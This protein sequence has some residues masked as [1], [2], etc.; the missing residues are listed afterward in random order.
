[1]TDD[2]PGARDHLLFGYGLVQQWCVTVYEQC[3]RVEDEDAL[4][5]VRVMDADLLAIAVYQLHRSLEAIGQPFTGDVS[6]CLTLRHALTHPEDR[7]PELAY[8]VDGDVVGIEGW[9][10][11]PRRATPRRRIASKLTEEARAIADH[12]EPFAIQFWEI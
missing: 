12:A 9:V 10:L 4:P 7:D 11:G 1:M 3:K 6:A 8:T 5:E 2:D